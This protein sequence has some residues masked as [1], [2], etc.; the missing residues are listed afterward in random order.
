VDKIT[1]KGGH[2]EESSPAR[3]R[4]RSSSRR[5]KIKGLVLKKGKRKNKQGPHGNEGEGPWPPRPLEK[6]TGQ[7]KTG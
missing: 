5:K 7:G 4:K 3:G 6:K 2:H 1:P